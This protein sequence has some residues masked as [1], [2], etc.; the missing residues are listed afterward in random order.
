MFVFAAMLYAL[1]P[2]KLTGERDRQEL[3]NVNNKP[4]AESLD[5]LPISK[6][7][8]ASSH[9]LPPVPCRSSRTRKPTACARSAS[10]SL[11]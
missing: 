11:N 8:K 7:G 5:A 6:N 4:T 3:Y 9:Y 2:P 10:A 1:N